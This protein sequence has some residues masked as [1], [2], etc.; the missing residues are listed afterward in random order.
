MAKIALNLG[1]GRAHKKEDGVYE[2]VNVDKQKPANLVCDVTK[3]LP[4]KDNEI[5][6]VA[7]DN[8]LEHFNDDE[9][10]FVMNEIWRV[11]KPKG[12]FWLRV[13]DAINWFEGAISDPTH[14]RFFCWPR[15]FFYFDSNSVTHENYGSAYGFKPWDIGNGGTDEK[16]IEVTMS[17]KK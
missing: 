15:S 8:L 3:G 6:H 14:K 1:C 2:W 7:A 17:P 9:F 13:P 16:F 11:L 4:Y 12:T 10:L 5:D